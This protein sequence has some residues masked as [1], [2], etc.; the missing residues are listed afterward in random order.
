MAFVG[1]WPTF[2]IVIIILVQKFYFDVLLFATH[3]L[4]G[5]C[6]HRLCSHFARLN[7][8]HNVTVCSCV[9]LT[10]NVFFLRSIMSA[11]RFLQQPKSMQLVRSDSEREKTSSR[12]SSDSSYHQLDQLS[13]LSKLNRDSFGQ[14]ARLIFIYYIFVVDVFFFS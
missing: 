2:S 5:P 7:S 12:P 14:C 8:H 11:F 3:I 9:R 1:R 6:V 13:I 10:G 4:L